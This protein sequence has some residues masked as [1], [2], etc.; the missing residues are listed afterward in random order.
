VHQEPADGVKPEASVI[1]APAWRVAERADRLR[2]AALEAEL[3]RI[4]QH[5]HGPFD[6]CSPRGGRL[7][8]SVEDLALADIR[9]R[10]EPGC[11][12]GIRPV[13]ARQW[14]RRAHRAGQ[15]RHQHS[16]PLPQADV[17]KLR[18]CQLLVEPALPARHGAPRTSDLVRRDE[19]YLIPCAYRPAI[20]ELRPAATYG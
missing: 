2:A 7:E 1:A 5:Q 3:G 19:S 18:S 17:V 12:L 14:D 6:S 4:L 16:Q 20:A 15:L 11:R 10:Q 9:V 8:V 13:L